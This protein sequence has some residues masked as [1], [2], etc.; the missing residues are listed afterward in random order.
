MRILIYGAGVIGSVYAAYLHAGGQ[1]VSLLARGQRLVDIRAH[2]LLVEAASSGERI[3]ADVP[4]V[5]RLEPEDV[6]D[7]VLVAVQRGQ[8]AG[9]LP[10]LAANRKTPNI[11]FLGNNAG[12]PGPLVTA[13]GE[14]RVLMGFPDIGGYFEGSRA[15]FAGQD[16]EAGPPGITLG[17]LD[18]SA[19]PRLKKIVQAFSDAGMP[20]AVE[21]NI[22]AWLKG[23]VA[24]VV[25]IL[26]GLY[27]HD[28][29]N[30]AL[31]RDR[32]TLRLVA[33]AIREGLAALR[34]LGTPITPFRLRT[35]SWLPGFVTVAILSKIISSDFAKVAFAGHATAAAEEFELL[36]EELRALTSRA[37]LATPALDELTTSPPP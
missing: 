34:E 33:R 29:D 24:L 18:G 5:E 31:A 23:H 4:A 7:L 9:V 17:E 14:E 15:R 2:G 37:G 25:P 13:L 21:A 12:G 8:I 16:G 3:D 26:F 22:D 30:Q 6:Y 28:L 20:V 1:D 10:S 27:R 35:I 36:L 32:G 19:S 11:V